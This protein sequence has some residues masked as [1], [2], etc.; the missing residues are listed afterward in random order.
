[1][2]FHKLSTNSELKEFGSAMKPFFS[3]KGFYMLEV[4]VTIIK[5]DKDIENIFNDLFVNIIEI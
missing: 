4:K 1:M 2:Y 5:D 3:E